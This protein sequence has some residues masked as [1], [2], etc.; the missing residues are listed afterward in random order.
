MLYKGIIDKPELS[1]L[2]EALPRARKKFYKS[3]LRRYR[4]QNDRL[5]NVMREYVREHVLMEIG[6][7]DGR[8][9]K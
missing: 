9:D 6:G 4:H 1:E 5:A 3:I 2:M 7:L 8:F